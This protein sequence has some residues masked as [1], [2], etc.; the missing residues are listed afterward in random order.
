M[1][2]K[3][4]TSIMIDRKLWEE[5][6]SRVGSEKGLKMLSKAIEEA[7]EEEV[8]E[9]LLIEELSKMLGPK[10]E[11]PLTVAPVRP[12]LA[13]DAGKAVREMRGPSA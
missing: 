7:I 11:L 2:D 8:S 5:F 13:T 9:S 4:K 3:V 1:K 10:G 12:K 6:R